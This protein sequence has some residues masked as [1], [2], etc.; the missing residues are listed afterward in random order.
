[1]FGQQADIKLFVSAQLAFIDTFLACS[2]CLVVTR[3]N[4]P[5][6]AINRGLDNITQ[7]S[8][9]SLSRSVLYCMKVQ[10][11]IH[12][13]ARRTFSKCRCVH[14]RS[15]AGLV[16]EISGTPGVSNRTV[17]ESKPIKHQ[18]FDCQTQSNMIELTKKFGQ[19]NTIERST[20]QRLVIELR[21][22]FDYQTLVQ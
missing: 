20:N 2:S 18:S 7:A 5:L 19:S 9:P 10:L 14:M 21:P 12:Q 4:A 1:M 3:N 16:L 6:N 13:R 22:M 8:F 15:L 17:R 11:S